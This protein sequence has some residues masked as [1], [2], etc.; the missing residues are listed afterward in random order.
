MGV[1]ERVGV[2]VADQEPVLLG[3]AV[4]LGV[5]VRDGDCVGVPERVGV[6]VRD[7]VPE[8]VGDRV[9]V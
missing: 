1:P 2:L 8:L 7:G 6:P 9:P 3:V 5:R 4:W